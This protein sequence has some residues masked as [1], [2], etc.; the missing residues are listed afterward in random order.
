MGPLS[1]APRAFTIFNRDPGVPLR[2]TPGFMLSSASRFQLAQL[3]KKILLCF[4][5][6]WLLKE[7]A[8]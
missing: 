7:S 1:A 8:C 6:L 2:S 3:L 4:L 5:W